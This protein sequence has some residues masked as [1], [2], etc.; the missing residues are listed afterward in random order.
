MKR[1]FQFLGLT[2]SLLMLLVLPVVP[3]IQL[4]ADAAAALVT[5]NEAVN[6]AKNQVGKTYNI[7][8]IY[9]SQC[10]DFGSAYINWLIS[11][12]TALNKPF[13]TY[14]GYKYFDLNYPDG[15]QKIR[16]YLELIPQPGDILVWGTSFGG[17]YGHVAVAIE[18]CTINTIKCI[19]Q[20]GMANGGNGSPV[21]Y[22]TYNY[23]GFTGVIRPQ[24]KQGAYTNKIEHWI[25]G[26]EKKEGNN[27][28]KNAFHLSDTSFTAQQNSSFVL[29]SSKAT[30]IPNGTVLTRFETPAIDGTWKNY[31]IGT[32]VT[33]K[34]S[35]MLF[36][37]DYEPITY[38]ITY[39][40]AGGTNNSAN[41]ATYNVF[42]GV[43]LKNPTKTGY[44]FAG[45]YN[46]STKVTGIN[47]GKNATFA[48][49]DVLYS[50]LSK[51]QTGDIKLT[52]KWTPNTYTVK[53]NANGGSGTMA[54]SSH[55]YGTAKA[56]SSNAFTRSGYTFQGWSTSASSSTVTYK[57]KQSVNNLTATNGATVNL[58]AV[59]N[60]NS[61]SLSVNPNGG[62]WNNSTKAQS[63][64]QNYASTKLIETPTRTGYTF[65]G[66]LLN[67]AGSLN[68]VKTPD[69]T[70]KSSTGGMGVY[71]TANN[72]SVVLTRVASQADNPT[73]SA[74]EMKIQTNGTAKPGLGGFVQSTNSAA[75]KKF[76][77]TFIAKLPVGYSLTDHRNAIGNGSTSKWLTSNAGTGKWETYAYEVTCGS[78][79][80]FGT[81]GYVAISGGSAPV[82]WYV[83][84]AQVTEVGSRTYTY[85]AGN[86]TLTAQWSPNHYT[87]QIGHWIDGFE[88]KEGNNGDKKNAFL[89]TNTS[90]TAQYGSTFYMDKSRATKIPNGT[91][92]TD[93]GTSVI[94]GKFTSYNLGKAVTQNTNSLYF[95]YYYRPITY[96]ITYDLAGGTNNS[97][98]PATYNVLY[99]VSLKNPTRTGYT[100]AG[101]YNGS[102]KVTGINEG[103]NA[104]F[105][106]A[107][108]LYSELAKRQ[109]GDIKLT[110]KWTPNTYTVKYNANGGNGTMANSS[111]TYGTAKALNANAFTRTGYTFQGWSTS[112]SAT[113]ETYTDKQSVNN[114]NATNGATVNLYAIWSP[115]GVVLKMNSEYAYSDGKVKHTTQY[116][117]GYAKMKNIYGTMMIPLRYV[118]EVNGF[119]VDYDAASNKTKIINS[120]TGE[121]LLVSPGS[122]VVEKYSS[123]GARVNE[124]TAPQPFVIDDGVTMG[125]MR[126][127][128]E[129]LGLHVEYKWISDSEQYVT[130]TSDKISNEQ[131]NVLLSKAIE[132]GL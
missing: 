132:L 72:G 47:E 29:D 40:L 14:N 26:F 62:T 98:N 30:R 127:V 50:E 108:A 19:E 100:F 126:F 85:G 12:S 67:G 23:N 34:S 9:G 22:A 103:K 121:Y 94:D 59:W 95:E 90:F 69:P 25:W 75:N 125:P 28:P 36:Q 11:G 116:A 56:L 24:W 78:S 16:N 129:A 120:A 4:K 32:S 66:W 53:Y 131:V 17:G 52:A 18:G 21:Q 117:T 65:G 110:A 35:S 130:V 88:N 83:A 89:L 101:W 102:T 6:W 44:T 115:K 37:Y 99:G 51:R 91:S 10:S 7:D 71:N 114:L 96:K 2:L 20:N 31:N 13:T 128:C 3:S 54:N 1:K 81:F 123:F 73:D 109:T 8:G 39:D 87:N 104:A 5:Q 105:A 68:G 57:D 60:I 64:T 45:W 38:K 49:A 33:Q 112:A 80:T 15:W 48:N 43:S 46:G 113:S 97:A 74:Y 27:S 93:F 79:G 42:Y 106:N 82:T 84:Y 86:C 63:F 118:A 111:H 122:A 61:Y 107:D 58:Y 70:F 76:I 41:P 77:H 92:V 119:A 124:T 55:N